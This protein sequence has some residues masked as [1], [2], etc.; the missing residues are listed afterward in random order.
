MTT[1]DTNENNTPSTMQLT[2]Q[3]EAPK[4]KVLGTVA[5]LTLGASG[6]GGDFNSMNVDNG[7]GGSGNG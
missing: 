1:Q 4:L 3:Y 5:E 2:L 6:P 7:T